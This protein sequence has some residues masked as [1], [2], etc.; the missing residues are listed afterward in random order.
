V[1]AT[2]D[3]ANSRGV[4]TAS[5]ASTPRWRIPPSL[6]ITIPPTRV[7]RATYVAS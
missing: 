4:T 5:P 6:V 7:A 1:R 3:Q 2:K